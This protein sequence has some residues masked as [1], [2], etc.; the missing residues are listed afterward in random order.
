MGG[1][2]QKKK[3]T[4]QR[5]SKSTT[6]GGVAVSLKLRQMNYLKEERGALALELSSRHI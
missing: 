6:V 2:Q 4:D 3:L 1:I 5:R